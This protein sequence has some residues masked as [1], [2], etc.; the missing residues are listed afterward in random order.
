MRADS[1]SAMKAKISML[2]EAARESVKI[3]SPPS[4][5]LFVIGIAA[6]AADINK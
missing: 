4:L 3:L 1:A 6:D 2:M 5:I